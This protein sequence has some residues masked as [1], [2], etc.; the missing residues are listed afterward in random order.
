M[1]TILIAL[2]F[3]II[4]GCSLIQSASSGR[5]SG[6]VEDIHIAT[7]NNNVCKTL[8]GDVVIYAIFVDSKYTNPWTTHDLKSTLDSIQKAA[9]W[10]ETQ[11][12][13]ANVNLEIE[14]DHYR[15]EDLIIPINETLLRRSLSATLAMRSGVQ[16]VDRWA[17]RVGNKA[18][19]IFGADTATITRTKIKPYDRERLMARVRDIYETDNVALMYFI[20]N[21][22]TDEVSVAMH[23]AQDKNP[24][25]A[26]VSGKVPAVIAHEFLHLFGAL[27]LYV[28]PFE[29]QKQSRKRKD[30]AMRE[31]PNEIMAFPYRGLDSLSISPLSGYLIGWSRHLDTKY[32][33]MLVS[34]KVSLAKY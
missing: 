6:Y 22:Y 12:L 31:F 21:Y 1:R 16:N 13:S 10:I 14:L 7:V 2:V 30:W 11:A 15:D 18:L 19:Q 29:N 20:N 4:T 8:R 5:G 26:V 28:S 34:E 32:Q 24:E 27:D 25:Y 3:L 17:D 9:K 33:K 23:T